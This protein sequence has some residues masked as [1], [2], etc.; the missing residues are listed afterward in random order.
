MGPTAVEADGSALEGGVPLEHPPRQEDRPLTNLGR[1][2]DLR[3][4]A[5]HDEAAGHLLRPVSRHAQVHPSL[6]I[7]GRN[8]LGLAHRLAADG[9]RENAQHG[10][11]DA[12][13]DG[14]PRRIALVC[15]DRLVPVGGQVEVLRSRDDLVAGRPRC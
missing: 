9:V 8:P 6:G 2:E 3:P 14:D 10:R 1:I 5:E 12:E 11:I 7:S 13:G 15:G 4:A